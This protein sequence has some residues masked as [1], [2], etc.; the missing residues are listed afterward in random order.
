MNERYSRQILFDK[1]GEKGQLNIEQSNVTIVGMGALGTHIAEQL[2]RAGVK[3]LNIIDRDYV[4]TSN[5]QRQTL[6]IEADIKEMLPKV[7]AAENH[8]KQ[9]REDIQ[10]RSYIA[11]CDDKLLNEVARYSNVIIDA[12]DNFNTRLL[13]NDFAYK[14]NIPWVY[15]ACLESTYVQATFIPGITPCFNCVLPQLPA[16]SRTCDTV[17]VISPAVTMATSLQVTDVLKILSGNEFTPKITYG[18]VWNGEH[19]SFG[20]S[21]MKLDECDTCGSNPTYAKLASSDQMIT[22]LCGRHTIQYINEKLNRPAIEKF[23]AQNGLLH[24]SNAYMIQYLYDDH[25]V[26]AFN[27]GRLL[28]HG[29]DTVTEGKQFVENMFG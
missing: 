21:Q 2:T 3:R 19:Q 12:T 8:L 6:F 23:V 14:M 10:I 20:F 17:G 7:V 13:I 25:R 27:N 28:I 22:E 26:V 29:L 11:Q 24:K 9:I 16:I 18:D 15:G 5:L 1:I 4:E